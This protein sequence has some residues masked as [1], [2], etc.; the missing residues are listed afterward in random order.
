VA[1][2]VEHLAED[3]RFSDAAQR[4]ANEDALDAELGGALAN[5]A[6][7][8]ALARLQRAG[9]YA[10]PVNSAAAVLGDVQTAAREYFVAVDRA[11]VGTHL[12]PGAVARFSK[13]PLQADRPAPLLGEHNGEV[14]R[15]LLGMSDADIA[16]LESAGVIGSAP[17]QY[18]KAS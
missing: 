16:E 12:Y 8:E 11:V 9:V 17:R 18:S 7:E 4:K 1:L 10:A 13:T 5:F 15:R 14:F 3:V 6:G 2:G